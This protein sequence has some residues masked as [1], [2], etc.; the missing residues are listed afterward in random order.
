MRRRFVCVG[1]SQGSQEGKT[2]ESHKSSPCEVTLCNLIHKV[3]MVFNKHQIIFKTPCSAIHH[4]QFYLFHL[5]QLLIKIFM[6]KIVLKATNG[7]RQYR[8]V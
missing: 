8:L 1:V 7:A 2:K 3:Q 6:T 4:V 5:V